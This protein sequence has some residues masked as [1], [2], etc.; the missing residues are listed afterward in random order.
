VIIWRNGIIHH[1]GQKKHYKQEESEIRKWLDETYP[2]IARR[3]KAENAEIYW[4]DEVGIQNCCNYIKGYSP[5]GITP[6]IPVASKHIRVNMISAITSGGKVRFHFYHGKMNQHLFKSFLHKIM[7]RTGKKV[8]AVSDNLSA[9]IGLDLKEW[10]LEN[11]V[12]IELF[13]L[14]YY[15]PHLN[16]A[17]YLNNNLKYEIAKKGYAKTKKEMEKNAMNI[18]RSIAA[19]KNRV[20]DFFENE[21]V[22]YAKFDH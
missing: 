18:M 9:H 5:R 20:A 11:S 22:K 14:P 2:E 19:K 12:R 10:A 8:Y 15:V 17:E 7:K 1:S 21:D 16:P 4:I 13:W 6:T 3:A